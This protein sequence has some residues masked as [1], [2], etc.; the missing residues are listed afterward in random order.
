MIHQKFSE[1]TFENLF[2]FSTAH[3]FP[4]DT[5]THYA[6]NQS[7]ASN[8][9]NNQNFC[10]HTHTNQFKYHMKN[11]KTICF[12]QLGFFETNDIFVYAN[13]S[14]KFSTLNANAID[15]F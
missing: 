13:A 12:D 11:Q 5:M 6:F 15:I 1:L 2:Q 9:V 8:R 3:L 14:K 4:Q 10:N 7:L